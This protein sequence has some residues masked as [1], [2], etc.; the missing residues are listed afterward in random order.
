MTRQLPRRLPKINLIAPSKRTLAEENAVVR[1]AQ[2]NRREAHQ[3]Q[4]DLVWMPPAKD[5]GRHHLMMLP[6]T[7]SARPAADDGRGQS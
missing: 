4:G 2:A 5:N 3:G 7:P 1:Q 6:P